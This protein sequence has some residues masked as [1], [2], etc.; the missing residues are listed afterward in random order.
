M[1]F[2]T[3]LVILFQYC[4]V[5]VAYGTIWDE[6]IFRKDVLMELIGTNTYSLRVKYSE[7]VNRIYMM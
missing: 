2:V 5:R 1:S 3:H 7:L 4:S 6:Y